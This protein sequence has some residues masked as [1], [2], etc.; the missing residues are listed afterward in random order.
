M[1]AQKDYQTNTEAKQ[2]IEEL[3]KKL[4][5]IEVEKL[6][7]ILKLLEEMKGA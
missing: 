1:Q 7:R 2:E 6:D 4:N 5:S 3:Q